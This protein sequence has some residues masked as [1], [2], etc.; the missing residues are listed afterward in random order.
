VLASWGKD[1]EWFEASVSEISKASSMIWNLKL[2]VGPISE[3]Y[4]KPGQF[5]QAKVGD[6]K[7]GFFAIASP[8]AR[9]NNDYGKLQLLVKAQGGT[10]ELLCKLSPGE[11]V[12]VSPVMGKGFPVERLQPPSEFP[13]VLLFATG[14]GISPVKALIESGALEPS[15]RSN[16]TLYFGASDKEAMACKELFEGWAKMGVSVVPVLSSDG[17]GYVQDV[18]A[19]SGGVSSGQGVGAVLCGQKEMATAIRQSLTAAGVPEDCILTNF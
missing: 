14:S 10:A 3:G 5:V 1:V 16:V 18:F 4:T 9:D 7:P 2:D 12:E 19:S 6:S 15:K 13:T 17:K 11:K 8:P